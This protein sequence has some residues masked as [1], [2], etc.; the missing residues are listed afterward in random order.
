MISIEERCHRRHTEA[1]VA[2]ETVDALGEKMVGVIGDRRM[3]KM[4]RYLGER[5]G[6]P[7]LFPGLRVWSGGYDGPVQLVPG[8]AAHV[9]LAS[10]THRFQ[11]IGF[12]IGREDDTELR[13]AS[14][15]SEPEGQFLGQRRDV[16]FVEIDG[17]PGERGAED[18]I[19]VEFWNS[20]GVGQEMIVVFDDL[21]PVQ[22]IA[23]DLKGDAVRHTLMDNEFCVTHQCHYETPGHGYDPG[24][25]LRAATL[26][27]SLRLLADRAGA[28]TI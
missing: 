6:V 8:R 18:R 22:E 16:T 15:H 1:F 28:P 9:Y 27:E 12:S 13:A 17:R 19:R 3:T 26:A 4:H 21:D 5:P 7:N 10:R 2:P 25:D 20:H 24:C 23:W 11:G 14:R